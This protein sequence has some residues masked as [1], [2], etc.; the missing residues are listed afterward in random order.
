MS[1]SIKRPA[2]CSFRLIKAGISMLS[3]TNARVTLKDCTYLFCHY[4]FRLFFERIK[5][6][7]QAF[8]FLYQFTKPIG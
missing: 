7:K 8:I 4:V 6:L 1:A 3:C 5:F 2:I